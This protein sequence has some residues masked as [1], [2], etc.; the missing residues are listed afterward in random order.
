[1]LSK[2]PNFPKLKSNPIKTPRS[3]AM[4]NF[5][6]MKTFFHVLVDNELYVYCVHDTVIDDLNMFVNCLEVMHPT[7]NLDMLCF[8]CT[9]SQTRDD[10]LQ[11]SGDMS[12]GFNINVKMKSAYDS[13]GDTLEMNIKM[14]MKMKMKFMTISELTTF[15]H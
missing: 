12:T 3:A 4:Y 13:G 15:K 5:N 11:A 6:S 10:G 14:K 1:M 8:D 2:V 9:I 7:K